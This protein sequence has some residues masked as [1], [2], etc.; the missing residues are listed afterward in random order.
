MI[1]EQLRFQAFFE[2]SKTDIEKILYQ[3]IQSFYSLFNSN[4]GIDKSIIIQIQ[5]INIF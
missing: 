5:K 3:P 4:V 1:L 2:K